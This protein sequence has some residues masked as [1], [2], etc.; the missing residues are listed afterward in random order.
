MP[1]NRGSQIVEFM[2]GREAEPEQTGRTTTGWFILVRLRHFSIALHIPAARVKIPMR[3]LVYAGCCGCTVVTCST[4][5]I[6]SDLPARMP[7]WL[8]CFYGTSRLRHSIGR[9]AYIAA[10]LR[11]LGGS[12]SMR[13]TRKGLMLTMPLRR[14]GWLADCLKLPTR[15]VTRQSDPVMQLVSKALICPCY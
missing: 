3:T 9:I 8:Q 12:R 5:A 1:V 10:R 11:E 7:F 15:I 2:I 4:S 14:N 6:R 13:S